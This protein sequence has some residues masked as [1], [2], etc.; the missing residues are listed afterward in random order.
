MTLRG[1]QGK[2]WFWVLGDT[3]SGCEAMPFPISVK[4]MIKARVSGLELLFILWF[5][6]QKN[7]ER[8]QQSCFN[9]SGIDS[10]GPD[11]A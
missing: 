8:R 4:T 5:L 11:K 3:A 9:V 1:A 6:I 10:T 7:F 2:Y